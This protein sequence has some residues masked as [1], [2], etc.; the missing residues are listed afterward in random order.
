MSTVQ[1]IPPELVAELA[2][3]SK[4]VYADIRDREAAPSL[5]RVGLAGGDL[6]HTLVEQRVRPRVFGV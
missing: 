5:V 1:Q 4:R 2:E 6:G 3:A